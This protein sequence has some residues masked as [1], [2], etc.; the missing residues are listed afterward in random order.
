MLSMASRLSLPAIAIVLGMIG[1]GFGGYF[2]ARMPR[3]VT[4]AVGP[5]GAE[6]HQYVEAI[7]EASVEAR[8]RIRFKIIATGGAAE[9]ARL[10]D[11]GK[12]DIAV[13][14][15]DYQLPLSG[16]TI[17]VIAKRSLVLLA[18]KFPTSQ[19]RLNIQKL[20]DL[21]GKKVAVVRMTD[22]NIPTVRKLLSVADIEDKDVTLF[23][24][25]LADLPELMGSGRVD[26][27]IAL[28]VP[29]SPA[30]TSMIPKL[31]QRFPSGLNIVALDQAQAI[32][33]RIV[34]VE[35]VDIPAGALGTGRPAEEIESVAI[36]YRAM[37][38]KSMSDDLAGRVAKS[39]YD[40]R[41]RL[42][43]KSQ[44]GFMPEAPDEKMAGRI[45]VHPGASAFFEGETKTLFERYGEIGVTLLWGLSIVGSGLTALLHW[46]GQKRV[47]VG[48]TLVDE[49]I[50]MTSAVRS[51][52]KNELTRI[53]LRG[54]AIVATLA[55]QRQSAF[56]SEATNESARFA[57]EH[58]RSVVSDARSRLESE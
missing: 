23:E 17:V 13:V 6:T 31:A 34:G 18:P 38:R 30:V 2:L 49:I 20:S 3:T 57:L 44:A 45:S 24:S 58:F 35:I 4:I 41:S 9:S 21:K 32:S 19:R 36:T 51:A 10:L 37:A 55:K 26:A 33:D 29:S 39:F 46:A 8:D 27:A 53:E 54:D 1:L 28:V 50:H 7:A 5:A 14:R 11:E 52:D 40:L 15:S 56:A 12:I 43:R 47:R 48:Q 16:Q 25:D 42:S 22:P